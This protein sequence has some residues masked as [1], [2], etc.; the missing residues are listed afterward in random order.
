[1]GNS[2]TT[3]W[4]AN[5]YNLSLGSHNLTFWA[6]DSYGNVGVS[7]RRYFEIS[8]PV[9]TT[10]P[11]ITILSPENESYQTASGIYINITVDE[12]LKGAWYELNYNGT[13]ILLGNLTSRNWNVNVSLSEESEYNLTIWANDSSDNEN[14]KNISFYVDSLAPRYFNASASPSVVNV[15]QAVNCSIN[16]SDGFNLSSVKISENSSGS[17]ENH[18]IVSPEL[19]GSF[20]Y[21]IVGNKL[22]VLGSYEC[23]FYAV[24]VAGNF[25][26]TS[27]SFLVSDVSVPVITV[28]S[29][30]NATYNQN[31]LD[32]SL[33]VSENSSWAGYSLNGASNVTMG[34]TSMTAWNKT[35]T[36]LSNEGYNI[37]F[38][39]K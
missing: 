16:W 20:S 30:S 38:F 25:N 1:M 39:C 6:N 36:S 10:A 34:N 12:D 11:A 15:S 4:N 23:R 17:F 29:P 32:V 37:Q 9:D 3:S 21:N 5:I 28:T 24:D 8:A 31:Y 26:S 13:K 7:A 27:V 33:I 14:T 18:S 22:T 19:G 35:L 2:S